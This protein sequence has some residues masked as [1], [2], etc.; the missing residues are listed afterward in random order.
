MTSNV[1]L[2][3]GPMGPFF[4]RFSKDLKQAG[5]AVYKINFNA[6][7]SFYYKEKNTTQ[8]TDSIENWSKFL[9]Q[10][11]AQNNINSIYLFGDARPYHLIAHKLARTLSID[12]F[13]FEEG[14]IRPNYITLERDGVN[15]NSSTPQNP[16][17]FENIEIA[18]E[19]NTQ[20]VPYTFFH[21]AIHAIIY[22]TTGW[23]GR[24]HFPHY[25][26]HRPFSPIREAAIWIKSG[27]R[28]LKYKVT[29]RHILDRLT[30]HHSKRFFLVPLQVHN[31]A[32]ILIWSPM[33]SAA[34]FIKKTITSFAKNAPEDNLLVIKHHPLDRGYIDYSNIINKLASR[35]NCKDRVIY[36]HDLHLPTLLENAKGTLVINS[37]VGLS[38][39]L[40]ETPVKAIGKAIYNIKGLTF[41]GKMQNFWLSPGEVNKTLNLQLRT[42]LIKNT[43][44][45][46]SFY[47]KT[48][49]FK[50]ESGIDLEHL[51][52]NIFTKRRTA[53]VQ[54]INLHKTK[55]VVREPLPHNTP[56]TTQ[57]ELVSHV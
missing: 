35:L 28:K 46:G 24:K 5:H 12:V 48:T 32:Q 7:D 10:Y 9:E 50:C 53:K 30:T 37:T 18:T 27:Y 14:Y 16:A 55:N 17:A 3:Q 40:H 45:N 49:A 31:D 21:T 26:H 42:H 33:S 13:V 38:S 19:D 6:A 36:V 25:I 44:V 51:T 52:A 4:K 15:G 22:Y 56:A 29:E 39:L 34:S 41:Q 8:Y 20:Q 54:P 2:L 23:L 1:L 43:Q 47:R 57:T 11:I